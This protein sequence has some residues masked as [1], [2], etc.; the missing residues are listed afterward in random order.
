V[1]LR[2]LWKNKEEQQK[3][4]NAVASDVS[5]NESDLLGSLLRKDGQLVVCKLRSYVRRVKK[6]GVIVDAGCGTGT[7]MHEITD[8]LTDDCLVVGVDISVESVKV[9]KQKMGD[10][11]FI[12]CDVD[13]LPLQERV[14]DMVVLRNVLH[15]LSTLKPL[16]NVIA[17]LNSNGFLLIDD[18][19]SGNP[20]QGIIISIYPLIPFK[21]KMVLR[22]HAGHI[23]RHGNLPPIEYRSPQNYVNFVKQ[24]HTELNI[25]QIH[26]H[27][28]FLFLNL[29][30]FAQ[31][32]LPKLS[33]IHLPVYKLYFLEKSRMLR[34]SAVSMTII[35]ERV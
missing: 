22:D 23:D 27:G 7:F 15:H 32:F 18:K 13:A 6:G 21:F 14:C 12:V 4:F 1:G 20:L 5:N 29:L 17:L 16:D 3:V 33:N 24:H 2:S 26:Y 11:E 10:A 28:F 8:G 34:W 35:A 9:A 30:S 19:I 31:Q 25:R